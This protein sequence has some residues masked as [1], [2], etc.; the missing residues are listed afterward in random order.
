MAFLQCNIRSGALDMNCAFNAF[1]PQG[2]KGKKYPVMYLLHGLTDNGTSWLRRSSIE[3][4]AEAYDLAVIMPDCARSF[5]TD[6]KHGLKYW[7]FLAQELPELAAALLP[8]SEKPEETFVA[9]L[10]MGGY[11]TLK[12][13]LTFPER[14]AA[15]AAF[16]SVTDIPGL[17]RDPHYANW[18]LDDIFGTPEDA[19]KDGNDIFDLIPK[20]RRS[21][22]PLPRI[23]HACGTEDYLY[24]HNRKLK[25]CM[26][27]NQWPNYTYFEE[28]GE[29]NWIF[30]DRNVQRAL[31]FF[32]GK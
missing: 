1:V 31:Q 32:F 15:A 11:G 13:A 4:Y 21:G 10:S 6:M 5:Y 7:T 24:S 17:M 2:P 18:Q 27:T 22:K 23:F 28:P 12:L 26:E 9:G 16:S 3:R 25:E 14:F 20:A 8:I 19:V 30:W 29:H